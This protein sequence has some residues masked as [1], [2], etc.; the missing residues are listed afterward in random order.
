M[1]RQIT[2]GCLSIRCFFCC[3]I[4]LCQAYAGSRSGERK[5]LAV[6]LEIPV[7]EVESYISSALGRME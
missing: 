6:A 2:S 1:F 4:L 5:G 7:E 3:W